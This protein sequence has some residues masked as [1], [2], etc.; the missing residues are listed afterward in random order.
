MRR[1]LVILLLF[2]S[3]IAHSQSIENNTHVEYEYKNL[4]KKYIFV[5]N[6]NY[7]PITAKLTPYG[8][9]KFENIK[10]G[11]NKDYYCEFLG[12]TKFSFFINDSLYITPDKYSFDTLHT[13]TIY[14]RFE[15]DISKNSFDKLNQ[16][17][18]IKYDFQYSYLLRDL[19]SIN[20]TCIVLRLIYPVKIHPY[21]T[22]YTIVKIRIMK[23]SAEIMT[24]MLNTINIF[25][26][27]YKEIGKTSL[28]K[29]DL[30]KLK[31]ILKKIDFSQNLYCNKCYN[32]PYSSFNFLM[33]YFD[34]NITNSFFLCESIDK[35]SCEIDDKRSVNYFLGLYRLV[36]RLN[37]NYF[38]I[39][40]N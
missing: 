15:N 19:D 9:W 14:S 40:R 30:K 10:L 29:R 1:L 38:Q 36:Y 35:Q 6:E 39:E 37:N 7:F 26:I 32:E 16:E 34:G 12:D 2:Y 11:H 21:K 8:L 22:S 25:N 24:S 17:T 20:D 3:S 31:S 23:T 33:E 28:E 4:I 18:Y 5:K 13:D 27:I